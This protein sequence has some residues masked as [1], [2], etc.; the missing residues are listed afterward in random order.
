MTATGD[1]LA[2]RAIVASCDL[3][4]HSAANTSAKVEATVRVKSPPPTPSIASWASSCSSAILTFPSSRSYVSFRVDKPNHSRSPPASRS[5]TGSEARCPGSASTPSARC[6]ASPSAAD[7]SVIALS[8]PNV[9]RNTLPLD[10][11]NAS[12][13]AMKNV[14]SPIS[15]KKMSR[16][17]L[18]KSG[19][20]SMEVAV[21]SWARAGNAGVVKLHGITERDSTSAVI[22]SSA[23]AACRCGHT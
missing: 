16:K 4:P 2:A 7:T 23:L 15:L 22:A 21:D 8:A 3:S 17:D 20:E 19:D 13:T 12:N 10:W 11:R 6:K 9:P 14:L 1:A 5:S 18:T